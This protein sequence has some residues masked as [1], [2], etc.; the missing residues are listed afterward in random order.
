ML[1]DATIT[2]ERSISTKIPLV[3]LILVA[4]GVAGIALSPTK[5]QY[6]P[7]ILS[8]ALFLGLIYFGLPLL[9]K[10]IS[11]L[12][13]KALAKMKCAPEKLVLAFKNLYLSYPIMHSSRL[14]SL[15]IVII[16]SIFICISILTGQINTIESMVDCD[17][18]AVAADKNAGEIIENLDSVDS[19][20]YI[21]IT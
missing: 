18:V 17:Y 3:L 20:F 19:A 10:Q 1:T 12:I 11:L 13:S 21:S 15:L 6:I 9:L 7:A 8:V 5:M 4:I 16:L 2:D 14:V